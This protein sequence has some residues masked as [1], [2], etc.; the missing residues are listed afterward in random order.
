MVN[1]SVLQDNTTLTTT[2]KSKLFQ[3]IQ[4]I[5]IS[6]IIIGFIFFLCFITLVFNIFLKTP[7]L[8]ENARYILFV[9]LLL[10]DTLYLFLGF[11]LMLASINLLHVPLSLCYILYTFSS[12]AFKITPCNLAAMA[13]EQ[14]IAI[15]HP[16]RYMELCTPQRAKA[17]FTMIC[18]LVI[19]QYVAE[20]CVMASSMTNIFNLYVICRV[21]NL[22]VNAIQ[23]TIQTISFILCFITIGVV[24]IFT[25]VKVML[26]ATRVCP[27]SSSAS[28][29]GRTVMIHAFQI[30]LCTS[31]LLTTLTQ[32]YTSKWPDFLPTIHFFVFTCLPRF[33]NPI[34]YGIRDELLMQY[35]KK[36]LSRYLC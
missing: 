20:F 15:C 16:L 6:S 24:I 33:L 21:E 13:V 17:V 8:R 18:S 12:G 9:F 35:I 29:A 23:K 7:T 36:S 2:I 4:W 27:E 32:A 30:L 22:T 25:Y 28:K 11:Y 19:I 5:F 31:P 34:I 3:V 26:V 14:Y 10:N 1:S